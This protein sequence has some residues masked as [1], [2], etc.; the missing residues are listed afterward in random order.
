[1]S[2]VTKNPSPEHRP[3]DRIGIVARWAL[4][5][6]AVLWLSWCTAV[7]PLYWE[8]SSIA[9]FN[10][11]NALYGLLAFVIYMTIIVVLV[12]VGRREP[13]L[14]W[15]TDRATG[16]RTPRRILP[17]RLR[18]RHSRIPADTESSDAAPTGT[19]ASDGTAPETNASSKQ[20]SSVPTTRRARWCARMRTTAAHT[21][22]FLSRW[23]V[24][25]T[26]R[27]WKLWTI[28]LVGWLWAPTTLF[29]AFG[30]DLRSQARE[31]SWAWNQ[32]TGLKQPYIGFFSFAPMDIYPTAHYLWPT[33]PTYLTDQHNIVLTLFYG[34]TMAASRYLTGSND[35]GVIALAA[36]QFLFAVCC[37]AA[38]AHRFLNL[39]WMR[40]TDVRTARRDFAHPERGSQ[41]RPRAFARP[42]RG[43]RPALPPE[44]A[45]ADVRLAVV[46]FFL[47]CPMAVFST[48]SLT[49][50][51]LFAFAF[52]WAFG[53]WYELHALADASRTNASRTDASGTRT[54]KPL[55][56]RLPRRTLVAFTA[57]NAIM[58]I[59]AK[60][61]WYVLLFE[62][63]L[64]I[65]ADRRRWA[66]YV[67]AILL[68]T[69]LIHGGISMAISSGAIIGGDPIESHGV[70]LQMI[71]RVA[72]RAPETIPESARK[73]LAP[74]FNL[75]QMADAYFPQDADPVKSSGIQSKKVSYR[76]RSVKPDDMKNFNKAW[77]EIVKA[78][79]VV[80]MDALMAKCYGYFD[81]ADLPYVSMNY[82][83]DSD[84]VQKNSTWLKYV[85]H[86]WRERVATF[87]DSWGAIPVLGWVTHGNFYVI[88]TLLIGAAE[89]I[90][91]R[92]RSLAWH[93]PLL[94]LMGVMITAPANNFERHMLP[95]A[96]CFAFLC[97]TFHR[98]SRDTD[99]SVT[100][101]TGA[102]P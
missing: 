67:V 87:A 85:N 29:A 66:T 18:R 64:A 102:R 38:T 72:E 28:F 71:A 62:F 99:S 70:Q 5:V 10:W 55:I 13:P 19:T 76:W 46:V 23:I 61:A 82:Y 57:A 33:D 60:Y 56:L 3:I 32:W 54:A 6:A 21:R 92:W 59:S 52:L 45:H 51:P 34:S 58:L 80:A 40:R 36:A 30:A 41:F 84:Y 93:L 44:A 20:D 4:A 101:A 78:N 7:G 35:W 1:M 31:F 48:I 77:L 2:D 15:H 17:E 75:D 22:A 8:D 86:A 68:P 27:R 25:L 88:L 12:R 65:A 9:A 74:V 43:M 42:E 53:F 97:L 96:F 47:V 98:D 95:V 100:V 89:V 37:T 90:L 14:G 16:E 73:E 69:I 91:K 94:L 11:L 50:S 79:P 24:R 83:V 63:V 81:I 39:P 26:D 49:K